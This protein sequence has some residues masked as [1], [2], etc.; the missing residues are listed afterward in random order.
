MQAIAASHVQRFQQR[1]ERDRFA[2]KLIEAAIHGAHPEIEAA[3]AGNCDQPH[4]EQRWIHSQVTR[5][6]EAVQMRHI[7]IEQSG[8]RLDLFAQFDGFC[9]VPARKYLDA[10][11]SKHR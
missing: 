2:E 10:N 4:A 9:A 8:I 3:S 1:L 7:E 11:M 6:F 5:G